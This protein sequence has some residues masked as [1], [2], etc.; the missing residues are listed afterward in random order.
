MELAVRMVVSLAVVVGLLLLCVRFGGKRFK[1]RS[2]S[3]L[4]VLHRQSLSRSSGVALVSVGGRMLLLGTTDQQVQ[5]LTEIDPAEVEA[6][7]EPA[8][9]APVAVAPV[10][11]PVPVA[12]AAPDSLLGSMAG[13]VDEPTR[14]LQPKGAQKR[15]QKRGLAAAATATPVYVAPAVT[16]PLPALA[17]VEEAQVASFAATLEAELEAELKAAV[18]A[19]QLSPAQVLLQEE[20]DQSPLAGSLLSPD[21][22]RLAARAVSRR[23]S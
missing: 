6:P 13:Q 23:A 12:L 11:T 7:A 1:G 9:E 17:P 5:M 16:A 10:A 3:P 18:A 4:Q 14:W 15:G 21:T 19:P 20:Q 8:A 22:W 2:G